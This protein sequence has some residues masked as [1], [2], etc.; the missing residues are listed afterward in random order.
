VP[1]I[2]YLS[3]GS[4]A[5]GPLARHDAFQKGLAELG[6]ID[7]KNIAI[8]YRFAD[9]AFDR[10]PSLATELVGLQVDVIV[11]V[12]TQAS[13]VRHVQPPATPPRRQVPR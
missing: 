13:T 7:G 10:L 12:V 6:Y 2:G 11:A 3:P 5:I 8:E 9:G 4:N 1:K